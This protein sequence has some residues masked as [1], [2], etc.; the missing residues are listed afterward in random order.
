MNVVLDTNVFVSGIFFKGPP[1][2]ILKAWMEGRIVMVLSPEVFEEYMRV[3]HAISDQFPEVDAHPF[4][5]LASRSARMVPDGMLPVGVCSDPSDDK[6]LSCAVQ[7]KA[8]CIISGDKQLLK[9]SGYQG[10]CVLTPR[11]F[12][13]EHLHGSRRL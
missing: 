1:F 5:R 2:E 9:A 11:R 4:L 7:G 8:E 3:I 10:I 6:F 13:D 12:V